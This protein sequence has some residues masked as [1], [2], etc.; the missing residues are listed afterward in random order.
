VAREELVV[1]QADA[2]RE[3]EALFARLN[4]ELRT[5]LN[6]ILGFAELLDMELS[7]RGDNDN[8]Q[9]ILRAG[10]RLLDFISEDLA[11]PRGGAQPPD[12]GA[13]R[14]VLYIEDTK[15][16]FTLV[17]RI[18]QQRP[19]V[20]LVEAAKGELGLSLALG[21]SPDIILLDLN[22]PDIHGSE[23]LRRLKECPETQAIPVVI[24]SADASSNRIES[25]LAGGARN[26]LTKPFRP[27]NLLAVFD[28]ICESTR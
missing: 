20:R 10:R 12:A 22:L 16:N 13:G 8:V 21:C 11:D 24:I 14:T 18:L 5:P 25:L 19:G 6:E 4:H 3:K 1:T 28:E 23:V 2:K 27:R 17:Q 7:N 15:A 26:Y 9:Q